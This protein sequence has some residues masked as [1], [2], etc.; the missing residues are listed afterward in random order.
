[1]NCL[2]SSSLKGEAAGDGWLPSNKPEGDSLRSLTHKG[3][4]KLREKLI[5][6][7]LAL[8]ILT[9]VAVA[10]ASA[11]LPGT[12]TSAQI[13]FDFIVGE[14]T[15][16][17]GLYELRRIGNDPYLL[18]IQNVDDSRN[19]MIFNTS[20]LD[21]RDSIR[22]NALVFHRYG[23]I[24]F[25]AEIRSPYEGIAR[26][27]QPSKEERRMRREMASNDKAP[28]SESVALIAN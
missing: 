20:L 5:N 21:D 14:Q 9:V 15:L 10:T 23:D 16:P 19:V 13:P 7:V 17:A 6:A 22:Q 2:S 24:Y 3:R 28:Q 26:E 25:L 12:R 8:S 1:M 18:C 11:Q 4:N 27:L